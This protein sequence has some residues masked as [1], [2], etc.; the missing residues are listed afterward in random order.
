MRMPIVRRWYLIPI[1]QFAALAALSSVIFGYRLGRE[2]LSYTEGHRV[3]PGWEMLETGDYWTP[4]L[5]G[6]PYVRKPPGLSWLIAA[7]SAVAGPTEFA[8]RLVGAVSGGA[9]VLATWWFATRWF[10]SPW[11]FFAGLAQ[12]ATPQYWRFA[13]SAEIEGLNNAAAQLV[14]YLAID[15]LAA[16]PGGSRPG[17]VGRC[18]ALSLALIVA[19]LAKGP[20]FVPCL[21]GAV[22]AAAFVQREWRWAASKRLW[23]PIAA[24]L[25]VV[26]V[27]FAVVAHHVRSAST[28]VVSQ[29]VFGFDWSA[30]HLIGMLTLGPAALAGALPTSLLIAAPFLLRRSEPR[31]PS[32]L[33][34][35]SLA[36]T[37]IFALAVYSLVGLHNPRYAMPATTFLPAILGFAAPS[38]ARATAGR[39][40]WQRRLVHPAAWTSAALLLWVGLVFFIEPNGGATSGRNIAGAIANRLPDGATVWADS[41]IEARPETLA[42]ARRM[43]REQG[44]S[45]DVRWQKPAVQAGRLPPVG[46]YLA[47]RFD[48]GEVDRYAAALRRGRLKQIHEAVVHRYRFGIFR[49]EAPTTARTQ[50]GVE[51]R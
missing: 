40:R 9:M 26:L 47:L 38:I 32:S 22:A 33:V 1:C 15:L 6:A 8:A 35:S 20:A 46:D 12:L 41:L 24:A 4:T 28:P 42:Y 49:V 37:A 44:R 19:A 27:V 34:A 7:G 31:S 18:L 50:Q 36:W 30:E 45:L 5:F 25:V 43:A 11:G 16:R 2:G 39:P 21:V 23:A 17:V 29:R 51:T 14:V 10:G 48:D 13:R 3:I